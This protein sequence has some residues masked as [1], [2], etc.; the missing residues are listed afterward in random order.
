MTDVVVAGAGNAALSAALSAAEHGADVLVVEKAPERF[1][2]GNTR[3][4]GGLMRCAFGDPAGLG[5]VTGE[6]TAEAGVEVLPYTEDDYATDLDVLSHGRA[7]PVLTATLVAQSWPT[8]LWLKEHGVPFRFNRALGTSTNPETNLIS[9]PRGSVLRVDGQGAGL[10]AALFTACQKAGVR[11]VY[12]T[13]VHRIDLDASGAVEAVGVRGA[14]GP[15]RITCRSLVVASGGYEANTRMRVSY[16]GPEWSGVLVRGV[17]YNTGTLTEAAIAVGAQPHGDWSACH[18]TIVDV[19][20]PSFSTP[21]VADYTSRLSYQHGIMTN[22]AG[23]RFL[24]EAENFH[25]YTYAKFGR[26]I[27]AQPRGLAIEL[28][29]AKGIELLAPQYTIWPGDPVEADDL[30]TVADRLADRLAGT[31][32]DR[33]RL[34]TTVAEY[35]AATGEGTFDPTRL[36]GLRTNGLAVEKTNWSRP[37]DTAPYRAYVVRCGITFTYGGVRI[38]PDGA[39]LDF[40]DEPIPGMFAAGETV[41]GLFFGNYPGGAGL[42]AGATFGRRAGA[43]AARHATAPVAATV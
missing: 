39:V 17:P 42:A 35:N 10:S 32:F 7:D 37:L 16:L 38:N 11:V 36:D 27:L 34:L 33:D 20:A 1:R 13:E 31:G 3:L 26:S 41:G 12:D 8:V 22:L 28:F 6:V 25:H 40:R 30:A 15:D 21:G 23:H 9:I 2:G 4:T 18:A 19:D 29:D 14:D 5:R 24:D 43:S